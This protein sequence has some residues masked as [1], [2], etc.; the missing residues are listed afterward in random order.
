MALPT[1]IAAPRHRSGDERLSEQLGGEHNRRRLMNALANFLET[2][3]TTLLEIESKP[4]SGLVLKH[5]LLHG[6]P[7]W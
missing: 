6:G 1:S 7:L 3:G 2:G 5:R 4:G